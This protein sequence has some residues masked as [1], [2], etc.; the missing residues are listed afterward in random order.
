MP[1][2]NVVPNGD[3]SPLQWTM[4]SI[5]SLFHFLTVDDGTVLGGHSP[6]DADGIET[7]TVNYSER[8]AFENLSSAP[9]NA[10]ITD[11]E[12]HFRGWVDDDDGE[13]DSYIEVRLYHSSGTE[14]TGNPKT[15]TSTDLGGQHVIAEC[16]KSWTGLSLTKTQADSLEVQ[17]KLID[18]S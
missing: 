10:I 14:V 16:T 3:S 7:Q 12:I 4:I 18:P 8:L 11:V 6:N 5:G 17:L 2:E 15:I 1:T 13:T 9:S